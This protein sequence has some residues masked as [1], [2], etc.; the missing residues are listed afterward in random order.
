TPFPNEA[1]DFKRLFQTFSQDQRSVLQ[2]G[3][4]LAPL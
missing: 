2:S 3:A 1:L 4:R